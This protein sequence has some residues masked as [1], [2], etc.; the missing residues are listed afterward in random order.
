MK[1]YT[2]CMSAAS[3]CRLRRLAWAA[4]RPVNKTMDRIIELVCN[5]INA[6]A[7]CFICRDRSQCRICGMRMPDKAAR[8]PS[9]RVSDLAKT[10]KPNPGKEELTP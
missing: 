9:I 4:G 1:T 8:K 5:R 10:I 7:V 2:C 3:L 6:Q